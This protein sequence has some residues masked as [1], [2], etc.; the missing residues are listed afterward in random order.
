[1]LNDILILHYK[2]CYIALLDIHINSWISELPKQR[3]LF[4]F[5]NCINANEKTGLAILMTMTLQEIM[6]QYGFLQ[7]I[8]VTSTL[9]KDICSLTT[10]VCTFILQVNVCRP[11]NWS[12]NSAAHNFIALN[13][14]LNKPKICTKHNLIFFYIQFAWIFLYR[15]FSFEIHIW[16]YIYRKTNKL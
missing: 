12:P 14:W 6:H 9:F 10:S 15:R 8:P 5:W 3:T 13:R 4:K 11:L 1:M 2:N 16:K 7:R